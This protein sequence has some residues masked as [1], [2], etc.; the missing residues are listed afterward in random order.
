MATGVMAACRRRAWLAPQR[1]GQTRPVHA[2]LGPLH[3]ASSSPPPTTATKMAANTVTFPAVSRAETPHISSPSSADDAD[4]EHRRHSVVSLVSCHASAVEICDLVYSANVS[5]WGSIERFYEPNAVY[6]NPFVT[7]TSRALLADIHT[8]G[9][10]LSHIDVPRPLAVLYALLGMKR[11]GM[12]TDPWFRAVKVWNEMG[13]VCESESLSFGACRKCF[14]PPL[15]RCATSVCI[16]LVP[17]CRPRT[18]PPF[19]VEFG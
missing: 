14:P 19:A 15:F 1:R 8:M 13:D 16:D 12:W 11:E 18:C 7:A 10:Q 6:E 5:A 4:A 9:A 3:C 17:A 2:K